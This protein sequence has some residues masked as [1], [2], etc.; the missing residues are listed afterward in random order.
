MTY[1]I[2]PASTLKHNPNTNPELPS[3]EK[4]GWKH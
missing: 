4:Y 2:S 1:Y 3:V